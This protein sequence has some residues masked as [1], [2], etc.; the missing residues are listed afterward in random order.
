MQKARA[1]GGQRTGPKFRSGRAR[2]TG[3]PGAPGADRRGRN[4]LEKFPCSL[5]SGCRGAATRHRSGRGCGGRNRPSRSWRPSSR[6]CRRASSCRRCCRPTTS[7]VRTRVEP[8]VVL[9]AVTA[10]VAAVEVTVEL[11]EDERRG[12]GDRRVGHVTLGADLATDAD[13]GERRVALAG[14]EELRRAVDVDGEGLVAVLKPVIVNEPA[15]SAVPQVLGSLTPFTEATVPN[16]PRI[17]C[18]AGRPG[19]R[20]RPGAPAR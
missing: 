1:V 6:R 3:C 19:R 20:C 13:V 4:R 8:V 7:C 16:T 11:R 12:R 17:S 18:T 10:V 2:S 5:L 14:G 9:V 15:A